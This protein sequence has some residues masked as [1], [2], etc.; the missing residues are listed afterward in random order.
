MT[1]GRVRPGPELAKAQIAKNRDHDH[2]HADDVKD[3]H[4][5]SVLLGW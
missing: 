2:D 4:A 5:A 3:V 1:L